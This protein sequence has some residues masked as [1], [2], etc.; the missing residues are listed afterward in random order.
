M[1]QPLDQHDVPSATLHEERLLACIAIDS[2]NQKSAGCYRKSQALGISEDS[3]FKPL[4]KEIWMAMESLT[5]Q[6]HLLDELSIHCWLRDN[7]E[8]EAPDLQTLSSL[9]DSCE[10][11]TWFDHWLETVL[12]TENKRQYRTLGMKITEMASE[13]ASASDM[14]D[15][16]EN[17]PKGVV[18]TSGDVKKADVAKDITQAVI[19]MRN[20][21]TQ[22]AGLPSCIDD[23]DSILG[24]YR[25]ASFNIIAARPAVGKTTAAL[26]IALNLVSSNRRVRFWSLE[27]TPK[28]LL[29]KLA[30]NLS[31]TNYQSAREGILTD[32]QIASYEAAAN[33]IANM[34]L[35]I[36][37]DAHATTKQI[38]GALYRD[39]AL[40]P[41]SSKPCLVVVDYLQLLTPLDRKVPREQ[42]LSEISRELK[43]LA[44]DTG[45]PILALAQLNRETDK[46]KRAPRVSDLRGSGAL[47]QDADTITLL[48]PPP[49]A[50]EYTLQMIVAKNREDQTGIATVTFNKRLSRIY[51]TP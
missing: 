48:H 2:L 5:G 49:D 24:G 34:P 47:E 23:Y 41:A 35:D 26:Q 37:D 13:G 32:E 36:N 31:K 46:E 10:T 19:E 40:N 44:K 9:L 20:N 17:K 50:D 12:E 14:I 3:F 22:L 15:A 51:T 25:E 33:A 29:H 8:E 38:A 27:M 42:Q 18:A 45:V 16:M 39:L 6:N 1:I 28:Q 4:H 30:L 43:L 21:Q 7:R 11:T